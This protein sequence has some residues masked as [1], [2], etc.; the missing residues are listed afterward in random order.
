MF[1]TSLPFIRCM[2]VDWDKL[3][4]KKCLGCYDFSSREVLRLK[5]Y[6][7]PVERCTH[8]ST[9]S[10][11]TIALVTVLVLLQADLRKADIRAI[12]SDYDETLGITM[13]PTLSYAF[14]LGSI[15]NEDLL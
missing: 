1:V 10:F 9:N 4:N 15:F 5:K 6:S 7:I 14:Q 3:I 8:G 12:R 11:T 13:Y 2:A